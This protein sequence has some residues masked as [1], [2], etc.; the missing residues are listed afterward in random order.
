MYFFLPIYP[1]VPL[2]SFELLGD[3]VL[4]IPKSVSFI[5]PFVLNNIFSGLRSLW[6]IAS[7]CKYSRLKTKHADMNSIIINNK[8]K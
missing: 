6:I 4:A 3:H 7:E 1:G 5:Y 8:K 2:V